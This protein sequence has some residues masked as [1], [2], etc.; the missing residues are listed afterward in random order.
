MITVI[1]ISLLLIAS[2]FSVNAWASDWIKRADFGAEGRHRGTALSIGNKGYMGLGHYNGA[3]PNIVKADWWEYD[4]A[5]NAW[6]QK[7]D[8]NGNGATGSY[9]V[10]AFTIGNYGYIGGGQVASNT[11]F[12]RYD[13]MTNTWSPVANTPTMVANTEGF[14]I[15]DKGYYI[16]GGN[17]YEYD[18]TLNNWTTKNPVPFSV[19]A[20]PSTFVIDGK[21]YMKTGNSLWEYKPT[22][23]QWTPRATFPGLSTA[24]SVSF[25]QNNRGYI[26]AGFSGSLANVNSE[27]WEFDPGTNTWLQLEEFKG[28]S[29]RYSSG[30]SI[31][32]RCYLGIGTN[33]TNFNDFW[34]FDALAAN[35][36]LE[37]E[38]VSCYPN[39]ATDQI[40]FKSRNAYSFGLEIYAA[41]G[42]MIYRS[43]KD[44]FEHQVILQDFESGVYFYNLQNDQGAV[45]TNRFVVQ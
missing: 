33:G 36:E 16:S 3:G 2:S 26:I 13:P 19:W 35:G 18:A 42:K 41:T 23:D 15:G 38:T 6:T 31:G 14:A 37:L 30:F 45:I 25:V 44:Q 20:W 7:A 11:S 29:R 22:L 43:G 21:G 24:G 39:P 12:H 5:T 34:E 4:P 28:T 17:L 32:N 10:L 8:Y 27:V 9:A 1:R 40:T